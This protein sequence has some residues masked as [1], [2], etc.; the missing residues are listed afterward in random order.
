MRYVLPFIFL[1]FQISGLCQDQVL[2]MNGQTITCKVLDDYSYEIKLEVPRKKEKTKTIYLDRSE[3]FSITKAGEE[4]HLYYEFDPEMGNNFTI[5]EMR[6]FLA[7]EEDARIG[8]QP[9]GT[10][11]V[12]V[13][14]GAGGTV[15]AQGA[16]LGTLIVPFAYTGFQLLPNIHIK[17]KTIR[18]I[19]HQY[20]EHY[21][22]GYERV[23]RNKKIMAALKGSAV[24]IAIG[25]AVVIATQ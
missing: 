10:F 21:A 11:W 16:L 24:G 12:G 17:E 2:M 7:G 4:E 18:N 1:L 6:F 9:R 19:N 25:L 20:N 22:I 8:Y 23:A 5:N 15:Y 3:I 14:L 13:A